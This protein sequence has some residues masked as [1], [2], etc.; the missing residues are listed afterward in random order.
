M[1]KG[2]E[3]EENSTQRLRDLYQRLLSKPAQ[4]GKPTPVM[5]PFFCLYPIA[6]TRCLGVRSHQQGMLSK[7]LHGVSREPFFLPCLSFPELV[8]LSGLRY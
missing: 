4:T 8:A 6:C 3:E 5:G 7:T 2:P 1:E